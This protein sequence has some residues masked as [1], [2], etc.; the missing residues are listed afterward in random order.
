MQPYFAPYAGYFRLFTAADAVVMF[1]CVQFP[2][3]GWVH[4]NRFPLQSGELD[5]L[6]LPLAKA[7]YEARIADLRFAPNAG[8]RFQ[9]AMRRFPVI[10]RPPLADDDLVAQVARLGSDVTRYLV[11]LLTTI[12]QRLNLPT[13]PM[14]RSSEM[15]IP[16]ELRA[17][18]RVIAIVQKLGAKRY[19]NPPGGRPLYDR[20][21]FE[22]AGIDLKFLAPYTGESSSILARLLREPSDI[23]ARE[24]RCQSGL[25]A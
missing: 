1:D 19:V 9:N 5:W 20:S 10:A 24:I 13:V 11:G 6:T 17:Q 12:C 7:P 25:V 14:L 4:R 18:D 2:R 15:D 8:E 3:R 21:Q 22:S 16:S 23:I